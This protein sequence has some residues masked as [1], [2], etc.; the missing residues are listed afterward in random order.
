MANQL[1]HMDRDKVASETAESFIDAYYTA[2]NNN[3]RA[4]N[5]ISSFYIPPSTGSTP[6]RN[7]PIINYNG[8]LSNSGSQ[9]DK[10]FEE[11]PWAFY[12]AQSVDAHVLNPCIDPDNV[13]TRKDAERNMS[14][15]VSIN[16]Y[17]RLG[18]RK[19][20][21]LKGFADDLVLVPNKEVA[22]GK[23]T[24]KTGEGRQWLIQTQNFRIVV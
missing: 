23:G 24:G 4:P 12:E 18:E 13:K 9:F 20:G 10:K 1:S 21:E 6:S 11:M 19:D 15:A 14:I 16:G 5:T 7:L 22:G 8:D 3:T 2:L 17:L